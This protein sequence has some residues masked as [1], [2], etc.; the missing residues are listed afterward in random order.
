MICRED[1]IENNV[2][3]SKKKFSKK[4]PQ[5]CTLVTLLLFL[6]NFQAFRNQKLIKKNIYLQY[7]CI[8]LEREKWTLCSLT[9]TNKVA[10]QL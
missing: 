2:K 5:K 7:T 9:W 4:N 3:M 1:L 8:H 10:M 6:P